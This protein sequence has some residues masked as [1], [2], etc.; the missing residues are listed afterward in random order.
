VSPQPKVHG[1]FEHRTARARAIA[2][3]VDD[4]HATAAAVAAACDEIGEL[5]ARRRLA[6]PMKIQFIIDRVE[7]AAQA[8]H[9]LGAHAGALE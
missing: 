5:V 2:L 9:D 8:A 6:Q 7:A 4:S 3:A 1:C